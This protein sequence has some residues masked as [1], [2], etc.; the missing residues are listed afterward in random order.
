[1]RR[2]MAGPHSQKWPPKY[3]SVL[4]FNVFEMLSRYVQVPFLYYFQHPFGRMA[5]FLMNVIRLRAVIPS[6]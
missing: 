3:Q 4:S 1:M 5:R 6:L 2:T